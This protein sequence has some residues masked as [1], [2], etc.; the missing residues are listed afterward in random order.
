MKHCPACNFSFPDFH[1]VCDFDGTELIPDPD[2]PSLVNASLSPTRFRRAFKSPMLLPSL[3]IVALF[4]SAL[5]IGYFESATEVSPVVKAQP[6]P[7]P[8]IS[9]ARTSEQSQT[10]VKTPVPAKRRKLNTLP[11]FTASLRR[12]ATARRSQARLH[13]KASIGNGSQKS[14]IAGR[15]D[16]LP[17][18]RP[19]TQISDKKQ[20]K[21]TAILKTTWNVMKKPFKF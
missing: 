9:V 16:A 17:G 1:R 6:S 19:P 3:V 8:S 13:Q 4:S 15:K 20:P 21:L 10:L 18:E 11:A 2:R 12:Q 7:Q 5:L 14:E